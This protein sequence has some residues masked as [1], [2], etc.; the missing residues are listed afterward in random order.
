[1]IIY[2]LTFTVSFFGR[3][4]G[5]RLGVGLGRGGIKLDLPGGASL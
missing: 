3:I 4:D 5:L 2:S 1:M